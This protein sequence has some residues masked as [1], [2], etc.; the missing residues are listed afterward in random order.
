MKPAIS[1]GIQGPFK[2]VDSV[3]V[4]STPVSVALY[5]NYGLW[6]P[7]KVNYQIQYCG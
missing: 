4:D 2:S 7:D 6:I 3:S 5:R 1:A